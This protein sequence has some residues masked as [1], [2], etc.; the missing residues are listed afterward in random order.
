MKN[1][2]LILVLFLSGS[3]LKAQEVMTD[4]QIANQLV[5]SDISS[6]SDAFNR[7]GLTFQVIKSNRHK[8]SLFVEG[9]KNNMKKW[10]IETKRGANRMLRRVTLIVVDYH[11]DNGGDFF[12]L[13]RY[14]KP[15]RKAFITGRKIKY[16]LST[17]RKLSTLTVTA[18]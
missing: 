15:P 6:V 12:D 4:L 7:M 2:V 11:M 16:K 5:K 8:T 3:M 9:S 10:E 14:N 18:E 17:G 1:I 13:K